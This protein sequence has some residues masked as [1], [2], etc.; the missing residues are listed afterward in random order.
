MK[1]PTI[2]LL[3]TAALVS[4]QDKDVTILPY[5]L[6]IP[7]YNEVKQYLG[8]S[9]A[10]MQSLETI[11]RNRNQA[12]QNIWTQTAEK[13]RQLYQML[14]DGTGSPAQ[15]GQLMID[16]RNLQKQIPTL[17]A[18]YR[19]QALNVLTADQKT[20]LAKLN[21]AMQ[22]QNT[23]W[24]AA[25]LLLLEASRQIGIPMPMPMPVDGGGGIGG[26]A[27]GRAVFGPVNRR[28]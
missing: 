10:Q 12:Q 4:A 19:A 17:E 20:K 1:F 8:L 23:V 3:A 14:E 22:L 26:T 27:S 28:P 15:I 7:A 5:P 16:V 25:A 6:P 9:D 11:L 18:P 13:N 24:Q 21:E 2:L